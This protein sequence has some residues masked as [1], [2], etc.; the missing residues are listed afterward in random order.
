MPEE[1]FGLMCHPQ[2]GSDGSRAGY[3]IPGDP[4]STESW[5]KR[6]PVGLGSPTDLPSINPSACYTYTAAA[7]DHAASVADAFGLDV[8]LLVRD[9]PEVFPPKPMSQAYGATFNSRSSEWRDVLQSVQRLRVPTAEEPNLR[10]V[11]YP[12]PNATEASGNFTLT[13][14]S[15]VFPETG[16]TTLTTCTLQYTSQDVKPTVNFTL[17]GQSLRIC[18]ISAAPG[19]FEQVAYLAK[20]QESQARAVRVLL[21][22]WGHNSVPVS[23]IS[24]SRAFY[25]NV[26]DG[27]AEPGK[28]SYYVGCNS[29]GYV[30]YLELDNSKGGAANGRL[31][32]I[33]VVSALL[34]LEQLEHLYITGGW[35]VSYC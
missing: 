3:N 7:G 26:T 19:Q 25:C 35:D 5:R 28:S 6:L 31:D 8:R 21:D 34:A 2:P 11:T 33:A 15:S 20:P 14:K 32:D 18:N 4:F 16:N 27:R 17:A 29:Q 12:D 22:A 9:N 24:S 30:T 13:L 10:C 23:Q 1:T